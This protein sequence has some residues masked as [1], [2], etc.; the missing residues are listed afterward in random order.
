MVLREIWRG[1]QI[2]PPSEKTI[3]KKPSL[4][5]VNEKF[6]IHRIWTVA[7]VWIFEVKCLFQMT[8]QIFYADKD[9]KITREEMPVCYDDV[10]YAFQSESTL[11]SCL[12]VKELLA[13]NRHGIWCLSD[14]NGIRTHNHLVCKQTLNHLAKWLSVRL[15]TN[16]LWIWFPLLSLRRDAPFNYFQG[17]VENRCV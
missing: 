11:Y 12:N 13:Q 7:V 1:C 15:R 9:L 3:L 8:Y 10:T 17:D 16:W 14:S 5:R 4:I 6:Y 2:D